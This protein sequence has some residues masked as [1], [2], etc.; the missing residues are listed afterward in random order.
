VICL[1][2]HSDMLQLAEIQ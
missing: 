1:I 2:S